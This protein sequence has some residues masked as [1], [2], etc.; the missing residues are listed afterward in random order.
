MRAASRRIE[1]ARLRLWVVVVVLPFTL[2]LSGLAF[3]AASAKKLPP[4]TLRGPIDRL[5]QYPV[6]S[7]ATSEQ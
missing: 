1:A 4:E 3:G 5:R 7:L 6:L 2:A